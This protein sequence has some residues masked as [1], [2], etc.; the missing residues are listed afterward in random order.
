MRERER[1]RERES[2][3]NNDCTAMLLSSIHTVHSSGRKIVCTTKLMYINMCFGILL[4]L[5]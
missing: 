4:I 5:L 1:E 3:F 2:E